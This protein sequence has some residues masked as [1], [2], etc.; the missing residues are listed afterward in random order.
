M[1]EKIEELTNNDNNNGNFIYI[2]FDYSKV[3][4]SYTKVWNTYFL[5]KNKEKK[6]KQHSERKINDIKI[7]SEKRKEKK[8]CFKNIV[9]CTHFIGKRAQYTDNY[10][11]RK[12]RL[13]GSL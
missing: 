9:R 4:Y 6:K 10:T 13:R 11:V 2:A 8:A 12:A 3:F 5:K 1:N 7:H